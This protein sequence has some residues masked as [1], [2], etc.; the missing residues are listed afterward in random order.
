MSA[1]CF[2]VV[3]AKTGETVSLAMQRLWLSGR[4]LTAGARIMVRH[5]FTSEEKR[6]LEVVYAFALPRDAALRRFRVTGDGFSV[7]SELKPVADAIKAYEAGIEA[8]H[9]STLARQYGD[10]VVNLSLGNLRPGET[11]AVTLEIVA[12]VELDD[13]G[14]RFRFP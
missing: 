3:Q 11:V 10:G 14:L 8:G 5:V 7:R 2:Q 9:L 1:A 6:P 4:V 13:G 12:G